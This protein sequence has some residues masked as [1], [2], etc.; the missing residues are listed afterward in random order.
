[1]GGP[2]KITRTRVGVRTLNSQ[3]GRENEGRAWPIDEQGQAT[4]IRLMVVVDRA[5]K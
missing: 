5:S 2:E 4:K 1:M 3:W